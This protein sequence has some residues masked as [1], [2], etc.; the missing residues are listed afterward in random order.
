MPTE[1]ANRDPFEIAPKFDFRLL[2][3]AFTSTRSGSR[4]WR[5]CNCNCNCT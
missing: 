3:Y 1:G 5:N 4:R 2:M